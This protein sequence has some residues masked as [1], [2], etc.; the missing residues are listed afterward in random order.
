MGQKW[1]GDNRSGKIIGKLW[2]NLAP[3]GI[4]LVSRQEG[5]LDH[6]PGGGDRTL[7]CTIFFPVQ[8][9]GKFF[10]L[11]KMPKNCQMCF[12]ALF[13]EKKTGQNIH[14]NFLSSSLARSA[15]I[16]LGSWGVRPPSVPKGGT[17]TPLH[18][19]NLHL[20]LMPRIACEVLVRGRHPH[21]F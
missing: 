9:A 3:Q 19:N 15:G 11:E 5:G 10:G 7:S 13:F 2:Y 18:R 16:F 1:G 21:G 14:Q 20:H 6:P 8:N 4:Y 12:C 17:L